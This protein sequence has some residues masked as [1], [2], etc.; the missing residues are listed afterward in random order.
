MA[1]LVAAVLAGLAAA[2]AAAVAV[3]APTTAESRPR[4]AVEDCSTTPGWGRR[5][6]FTSRQNLVV[7]PFAVERGKVL[8]Y[9]PKI[10]GEKLFVYVRGGHRATV[11]LPYRTRKDGLK[12]VRIAAARFPRA[13]SSH[14]SRVSAESS[15]VGSTAGR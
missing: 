2:S 11:E 5:D 12:S 10:G 14:S 8:G 1:R 7:G 4:G 9:S 3:A 15:P 13:G 6:E